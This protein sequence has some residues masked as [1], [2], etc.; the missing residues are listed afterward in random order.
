[1]DD[2]HQLALL[3]QMREKP[4]STWTASDFQ[5]ALF[6]APDAIDADLLNEIPN[7]VL[8]EKLNLYD[9]MSE[10]ICAFFIYHKSDC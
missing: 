8:H 10:I 4:T 7:S 9:G 2:V 1:M 5:R 6:L 3:S